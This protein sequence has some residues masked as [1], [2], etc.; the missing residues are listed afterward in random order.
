MPDQREVKSG[1]RFDDGM[2]GFAGALMGITGDVYKR[3]APF[4]AMRPYFMLISPA[5]PSRT[6]P[7]SAG[8]RPAAASNARANSSASSGATATSRPPDVCGSV[9]YTHLHLA[10]RLATHRQ[11]RS[12]LPAP[13]RALPYRV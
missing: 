3:Q 6:W 8:A 12:G 13:F 11:G 5:A 2:L 10:D 9:S 1:Q 4:G 7:I